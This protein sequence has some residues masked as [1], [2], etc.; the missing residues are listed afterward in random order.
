MQAVEQPE[1]FH[2]DLRPYQQEGLGWLEFLQEFGFGGCLA[3]DM[4]LGKTIQV[5]AI[6]QDRVATRKEK[7]PSLVVVPKSLIFN[8]SHEIQRFTPNLKSLEYT[9][10]NRAELLDSLSKYDIVLT[11]YGTLRRDVATLK[12]QHFDYVVLDEAQTIKNAASQVAK[13]SRLLDAKYRLGFERYS[14]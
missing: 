2:G 5:L 7:I 1:D 11:T 9:G 3:D 13:A 4:G 12:D 14:N 6:L 8:W 10:L